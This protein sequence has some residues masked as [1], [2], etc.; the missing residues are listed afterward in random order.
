MEAAGSS[1]GPSTGV[2]NGVVSEE[3]CREFA[4][5]E[6]GLGS[7]AEQATGNHGLS[8]YMAEVGSTCPSLLLG[9]SRCLSYARLW[10]GVG[11]VGK[12]K[13][14]LHVVPPKFGKLVAHPALLLSMRGNFQGQGVPFGAE[15]T[16]LGDE[17]R[18]QTKPFLRLFCFCSTVLLRVD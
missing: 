8:Q 2:H 14:V 5:S 18:S 4:A 16:S 15:Q 11:D 7:S 9:I 1:V 10:G 17:M 12:T 6:R 13:T 3:S